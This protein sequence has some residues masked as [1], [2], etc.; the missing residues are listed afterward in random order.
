M[1]TDR[2]DCCSKGICDRHQQGLILKMFYHLRV[3]QRF[4]Q[5]KE[6]DECLVL[7]HNWLSVNNLQILT[8]PFFLTIGTIGS[9]CWIWSMMSACCSLFSLSSTLGFRVCGTMWA[10]Q[11]FGFYPFK[12]LSSLFTENSR[13]LL[14]EFATFSHFVHCGL[15]S[16]QVSTHVS[17][18][19]LWD[20]VPFLQQLITQAV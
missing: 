18:Y 15:S 14:K 9:E 3:K 4:H 20:L 12:L 16:S 10:Q 7:L 1:V 17:S 8:D 6:V 11:S 13:I 5:H 2:F 19:G